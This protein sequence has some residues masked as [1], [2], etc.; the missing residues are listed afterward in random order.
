M[1]ALKTSH[2]AVQPIHRRE[3]DAWARILEKH[4]K[5]PLD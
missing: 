2:A 5:W 4:S 1:E 3:L